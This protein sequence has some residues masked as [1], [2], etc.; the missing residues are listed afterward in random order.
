M[1]PSCEEGACASRRACESLIK[2]AKSTQKNSEATH[3]LSRVGSEELPHSHPDAWLSLTT[4][5]LAHTHEPA[6]PELSFDVL[7]IFG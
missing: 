6:N 7:W 3:R 1:P 4:H 2:A 5:T